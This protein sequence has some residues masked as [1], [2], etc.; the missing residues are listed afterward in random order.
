MHHSRVCTPEQALSYLTECSLATVSH[1]S[2]LKSKSKSEFERQ[3][4]IAQ[5]ACDWM[6]RFGVDPKGTR[7]ED[8]I[9][10]CTVEEWAK[11]SNGNT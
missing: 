2:M 7:A 5:R 11:N 1:M 6:D 10:K 8:I 3:I 4:S 9:G